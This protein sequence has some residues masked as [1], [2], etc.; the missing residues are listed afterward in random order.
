MNKTNIKYILVSGSL[1]Y[2][3]IMDFPGFFK[4]H[5]MPDK[6]HILNVSF[7]VNGV[8]ESYGGTAGNIAY[9]LSLLGERPTIFSTIGKDFG[10]YKSWL[11]RRKSDLGGLKLVKDLNTASVFVVTDRAD[12]QIAAFN[13][14]AMSVPRGSFAP[15][16]LKNALAIISPGNCEDMLNYAKTYQKQ[17]VRYIFDPGQQII[18]LAPNALKTGA[19]GAEILIGNDYEIEL[20]RRK[21]KWTTKRLFGKIN[22]LIITKSGEGSEIYVGGKRTAIKAVKVKKVLD[23]TGAGDAYR[24]GLIKGLIS[25]L[26][27]EES[28]KLASAV[29]GY[30]VESY[31]TQNHRFTWREL[32]QKFKDNYM[33]ELRI[34]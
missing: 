12:N 25:D 14:G 24:A 8:K 19:I 1:V 20:I 11:L 13:P 9:N 5:I 23:P 27:L 22:T 21:L 28:A 15:K 4:D 34:N 3:R 29:A 33:T 2:D 32:K 31:G 7:V 17:R 6:I 30:A 10:P 16:Y 18:A 26:P